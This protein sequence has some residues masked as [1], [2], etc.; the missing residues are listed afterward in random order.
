MSGL[1]E[2]GEIV[3][4]KIEVICTVETAL[5]KESRY[6]GCNFYRILVVFYRSIFI[7]IGI[8]AQAEKENKGVPAYVNLAD[9]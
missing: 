2:G 9:F 5:E 8:H 4:V 1:E 6:T 7:I 3:S